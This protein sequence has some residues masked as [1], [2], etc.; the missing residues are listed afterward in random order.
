MFNYISHYG[1]AHDE[2]PPGRGSGRWPWGS[3]DRPNQHDWSILSRIDKL[4]AS[5]PG[6]KDSEI[7]AELGYYRKDLQGNYILDENG[8]KIGS[9]A[10]LKAARELAIKRKKMDEYERICWYDNHIDPDTGKHYTDTKIAELEGWA[11]ES[12][13]RSKRSTGLNGKQSKVMDVAD[14]L[15][16]ECSKKG[17][18]DVGSSVELYLGTSPNGL[19][20]ALKVLEEEGYI[21]QNIRVKQAAN[22][23]QETPYKV[24]I[25]PDKANDK[26]IYMHPQ[27]IKM[28]TDP[29]DHDNDIDR[30]DVA[31]GMATPPQVA[32]NRIKIRYAED[33]GTERD[34][35]IEIR[36]VRD[37]NGKLVAASPDLSL[38]NAKYAQVRI[39]VEGDHYIKG[40]ATYNE[41]LEEGVDILV[42]S[43]KSKSKG[44]SGALKDLERDSDGS[45]SKNMFGSAVVQTVIRD[46]DGNPIL[47]KNGN[48]QLSAINIV[49]TTTDDMHV[50][51]RWGKWSK[52]LPHQ[53]LE[54]Q[55]EV[56][57]KKQL[58]QQVKLF[59]D[60]YNEIISITNPTVRRQMLIDFA[61]QMDAAACDL[62][63]APIGGQKTR[64]LLPVPSLKDNECYCPGLEN[65]TI[66]ALVRFP[67]AGQW[68]I[69]ILKV[70]NNN[71]EAKSFMKDAADAIGI[72]HHNHGVLSGADSD[73][74]TAIVIPMTRKNHKTGEFEKVV[75]IKNMPTLE[76]KLYLDDKGNYETVKIS[77][78]DTSA[79]YS[80]SNPRFSKMVD[81]NGNPTYPYFKT[82]EAKGKEMGIISNLITD[83][84]NKGCTDPDELVRADM[85]SMVVIDAK[86]H[87]L[88]YKQ[89][90]KD[91]GIEELHIKYQGKATG[92]AASLLSR[93]KSPIEVPLRSKWG[94]RDIDINPETGEKLYSYPHK[95]TENKAIGVEKVL[96][97][98]GYIYTDAQG[99]PHKSKYLR[100]ADGKEV[101]A[102]W[103]GKIVKDKNGNY[104]YDQGSGKKKFVYKEVPRT[105]DINK[106]TYILETTGDAKN[107]LSNGDESPIIEKTYAAYAN[108]CYSLANQARKAAL[109]CKPIK[110]NKEATK[111]YSKEVEELNKALV[112]AKQAAPK[113]RQANLLA[114]QLI[115]AMVNDYEGEIDKDTRSKIRGQC[116][117]HARKVCNST[118]TRI[119]FTDKQ[120]EAINAG[121]ISATTL[122]SLLKNADKK[123][124]VKQF[125]PKSSQ[126]S[127]S[128][129]AL[130][131][132][133]Y[134]T[135]NWSYEE[136]AEKL[137]ISAGSVSNV[138]NE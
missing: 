96:A 11:G 94:G 90:Y 108:H 60:N 18:I 71:A 32:L 64:V 12:S 123:E 88:N 29:T 119:I 15:K 44:V 53:F 1:K 116:L 48:Q 38:G 58:K 16:D 62:K 104:I 126:L 78:F 128:K 100:D 95:K 125:L 26:P 59:E 40:M 79:A 130:I 6:I 136:I 137:G 105:E 51:G 20:A 57:V 74:D 112:I 129:K 54:K 63:A 75:D 117:D 3:G 2:D 27:D 111:L 55:S 25:P 35:Q 43:N 28:V 133:L 13:V 9:A 5:T 66:V 47:D 65:G 135:N 49:G 37:E 110:Q 61:D 120:I 86:K 87:K 124:Y 45:I 52:N 134:S 77:D 83:M 10:D 39:A 113:E 103:D 14:K 115:N 82:E 19:S 92:G 138:I 106:M 132:Q 84:S 46:K 7:A 98:A 42:N 72:N 122:S 101:A 36:A 24:L 34:G 85:Y 69:P 97:P 21:V 30:F 91:Y 31:H 89:A 70:N 41:N 17:Y 76:G 102:T 114:T 127:D 99:K 33:N 56:L 118:K 131:R 121:A 109:T 50:E 107:L 4:K 67:H 80:T 81:K 73:G 68:E 8:N 93:S 23:S 22:P